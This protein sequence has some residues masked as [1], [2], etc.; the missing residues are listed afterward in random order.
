MLKPELNPDATEPYSAYD[1]APRLSS[2]W[3]VL[4]QFKTNVVDF[5]SHGKGFDILEKIKN[6][7]ITV[8]NAISEIDQEL[9]RIQRET[10]NDNK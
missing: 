1:Q 8:S 9:E 5:L 10:H 6:G 2:E 4:D 3:S 7:G